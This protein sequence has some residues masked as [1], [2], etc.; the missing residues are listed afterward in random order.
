MLRF[1]NDEAIRGFN[2]R[3]RSGIETIAKLPHMRKDKLQHAINYVLMQSVTH[4]QHD[5]QRATDNMLQ[6]DANDHKSRSELP[7]PKSAGQGHTTSTSNQ[8]DSPEAGPRSVKK[9]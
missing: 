8:L 2:L 5:L 7:I 1:D 6:P 9:S 3:L 4:T